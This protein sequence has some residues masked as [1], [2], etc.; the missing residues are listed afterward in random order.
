MSNDE[1]TFGSDQW[2]YCAQHRRAHL[3][4]WCTVG[5]EDKVGLGIPLSAGRNESARAASQKCRRLGLPLFE[6]V[7][8][9]G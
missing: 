6:E 8:R 7:S 4:G 5:V 3:T 1:K 9:G 2:I